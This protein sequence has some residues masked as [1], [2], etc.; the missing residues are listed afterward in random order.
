MIERIK[1]VIQT[2]ENANPVCAFESPLLTGYSGK[3][4]IAVLQGLTSLFRENQQLCYLEIG[5]F[6]G[7]TLLSVAGANPE[8]AC[9]GIDNFQ[10]YDPEK[11][12]MRIFMERRQKLGLDN[13]HLINLDYEDAFEN[14][15]A[16]TKG[17]KIGLLFIDGPHDY[18]S[19]LMGLMLAMPY[20]SENAVIVVDDS[21]YLHVRQ[22]NTDFLMTHPEY[23]LIFQS[24][25]PCHP[26]NMTAEQAERARQDWWNGV[27]IIVRDKDNVLPSMY[28]P[29]RRNRIL[30][31][32]DHFTHS[33]RIGELSPRA[34]T[35]LNLLF[36]G[37]WMRAVKNLYMAYKEYK[38]LCLK[39]RFDDA[40]TFLEEVPQSLI[41]C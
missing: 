39:N 11:Q 3:R 23:K 33:S 9:F 32:N 13:A 37:R 41:K 36:T 10:T 19:Q 20:L 14:L 17:R 30:F 2:V 25:T 4:L 5:V 34:L 38:Q 28:P 18:R 31:E 40:N 22:A 35:V 27:N 26:V 8:V 24:Y 7:L 1:V 15:Y 21:N 12:N 29:T 16:H 6:Q